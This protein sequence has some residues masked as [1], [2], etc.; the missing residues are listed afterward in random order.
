MTNNLPLNGDGMGSLQFL[1]FALCSLQL[2]LLLTLQTLIDDRSAH[3]TIVNNLAT[4]PLVWISTNIDSGQS[5]NPAPKTIAP[6]SSG[7]FRVKPPSRLQGTKGS[8]TYRVDGFEIVINFSCP[9]AKDNEASWGGAYPSGV[10]LDHP[11]FNGNGSP[12]KATFS[13]S[14]VLE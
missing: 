5:V 4:S 9:F 8:L 7:V 1:V 2:I 3:I 14:P 12:L 6:R 11:T 13:F 10:S